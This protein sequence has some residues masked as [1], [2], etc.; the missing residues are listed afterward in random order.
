MARHRTPE[1]KRELGERARALRAA[2]R[3]RREIQAELGIGDDLAKAFL[4]GVPLPDSLQRP[5]AKD[6]TRE[7]AVLLRQAGRTYDQIAVELGI[8]KSTCSL[9]LRDLSQPAG[10]PTPAAVPAVAV[11][12]QDERQEEARRLRREGLTLRAIGAALGMSAKSAYYWT[13]DLPVPVPARAG[14]DREHM[15]MMRRRYW[16]RVLAER[17]EE[18]QEV[19]REHAA[20]V[21]ALTSWEL[22]LAA[23]TA[24]WCE[25]SKSKT[26]DRREQVTFIN[27]DPGL[28]LLFLAW[29]DQIDFPKENR[30]LS[31]SI[32]ESADLQAA[33]SWW[34]DVVGV[35]QAVFGRPNLKR[36]NPKTVRKNVD[37]A[38]VGCLVVRLRQCRTL[39][40]RI[41]GVWQGIMGALPQAGGDGSFPGRLGA[42]QGTLNP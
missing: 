28:I 10:L 29:L 39:Y 19:R 17:E 40:Q 18:R 5:W 4:R 1:E 16:D 14:R 9:W 23:V 31:L 21:E 11:A 42:G 34:A 3:S 38:Y 37:E 35:E 15:D 30:H 22:E 13:W 36:H 2:G 27:S 20:R 41:E 33:T 7:A 24:Y 32:H 8:S 12:V 25:G 26:Y 6:A